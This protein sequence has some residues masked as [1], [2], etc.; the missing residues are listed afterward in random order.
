[1]LENLQKKKYT[2]FDQLPYLSAGSAECRSAQRHARLREFSDFPPGDVR[3]TF[4]AYGELLKA[5]RQ[6][7]DLGHV[8]LYDNNDTQAVR[9]NIKKARQTWR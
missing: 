7:R 4:S 5:V 2:R 8:V 6:F 1:M 3:Q 9:C